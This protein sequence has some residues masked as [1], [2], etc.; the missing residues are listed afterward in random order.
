EEPS[1]S[2]PGN[3][4]AEDRTAAL[5]GYLRENSAA[6]SAAELHS[7]GKGKTRRG[8]LPRIEGTHLLHR[9][10]PPV[11][12]L[13]LARGFRLLPLPC[14]LLPRNAKSTAQRK[15]PAG[16][17]G[18]QTP[19][20]GHCLPAAPQRNHTGEDS[21]VSQGRGSFCSPGTPAG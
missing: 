16:R 1:S 9:A 7:W 5:L 6:A 21:S 2:R 4:D 17:R 10:K 13:R 12:P 20:S 19:S 11:H 8:I 14:T 18:F 15:Y 3:S